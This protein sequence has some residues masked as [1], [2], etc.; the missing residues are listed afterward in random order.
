MDCTGE[1]RPKW[2]H[3]GKRVRPRSTTAEHRRMKD[4][5]REIRELRKTNENLKLASAYF[6]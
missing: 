3:Q 2:V 4:H 1:T 5:E 6:A